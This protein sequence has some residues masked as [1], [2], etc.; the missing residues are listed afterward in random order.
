MGPLE[1]E[2]LWCDFAE[3]SDREIL[4]EFQK[5]GLKVFSVY[6]GPLEGDSAVDLLLVVIRSYSPE[7]MNESCLEVWVFDLLRHVGRDVGV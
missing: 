1:L 3:H 6:R 7:N 2:R 4:F 5:L